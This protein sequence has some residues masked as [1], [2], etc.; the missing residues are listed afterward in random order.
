MV[1][2][3]S[4]LSVKKRTHAPDAL[5]PPLVHCIFK[6]SCSR[7]GARAQHEAACT[8]TPGEWHSDHTC[9]EINGCR[10]V[11]ASAC[12]RRG[13]QAPRRACTATQPTYSALR[14]SFH[15]SFGTELITASLRRRRACK[16]L[17]SAASVR[18]RLTTCSAGTCAFSPWRRRRHMRGQCV[19]TQYTHI[20]EL[21]RR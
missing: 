7:S 10:R 19:H 2:L 6:N 14:H 3:V 15:S 17:T 4:N 13:C 8:T 11:E 12:R 20:H 21:L 9:L 18:R 1:G 16:P 5:P